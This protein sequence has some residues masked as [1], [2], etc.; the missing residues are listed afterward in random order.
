M[1]RVSKER[2]ELQDPQEQQVL[3]DQMEVLEALA[4]Q[5]QPELQGILGRQEQLVPRAQLDLL[6]P[7]D[8]R[9]KTEPQVQLVPQEFQEVQG[10]SA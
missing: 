10:Q 3:V 1:L 6:D 8:Y 5:E 4:L 2:R 9:V 7:R